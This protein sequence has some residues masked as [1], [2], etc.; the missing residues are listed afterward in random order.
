MKLDQQSSQRRKLRHWL[1][2]AMRLLLV[3]LLVTAFARPFLPQGGVLPTARQRRQAIFVMDRSASMLA[4]G[5]D[6]QRWGRAK[7]LVQ[8]ALGALDANDQAALIGCSNSTSV[9]SGFVPPAALGKI[10][11]KLQPTCGTSS[12]V[13]GMQQAVKLAAAGGPGGR[14]GALCGE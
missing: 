4:V 3:G 10:I 5:T 2:L 7:D 13:E 9:L 14:N 8:K 6:G 11:A 1:L 12:L